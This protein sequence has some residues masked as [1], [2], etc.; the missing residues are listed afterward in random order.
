MSA[1][2]SALWGALSFAGV[3][4][5][6]VVLLWLES[7]F[8]W[9]WYDAGSWGAPL[10]MLFVGFGLLIVSVLAALISLVVILA[11][12]RR[13]AASAEDATIGE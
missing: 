5:I 13:G 8:S 11:L 4:A 3:G 2:K 7:V 6:I 10:I 9:G 12:K 1:W